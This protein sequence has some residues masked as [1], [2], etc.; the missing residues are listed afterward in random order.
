VFHDLKAAFTAMML[1][2]SHTTDSR[3]AS[4]SFSAELFNKFEQ[5]YNLCFVE[6]EDDVSFQG[7]KDSYE[8]DNNTYD[9]L[10]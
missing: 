6:E 4:I 8:D 7:W 1:S 5:E 10:H 3:G 9:E 2:C